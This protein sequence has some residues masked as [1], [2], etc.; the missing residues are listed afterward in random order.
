MLPLTDEHTEYSPASSAFLGSHLCDSSP[1]S[2]I[3]AQ[4]YGSRN[5][6]SLLDNPGSNVGN[7]WWFGKERL[8]V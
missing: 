3:A 2:G 7:L 5:H 6:W 8:Y 4:L 1:G